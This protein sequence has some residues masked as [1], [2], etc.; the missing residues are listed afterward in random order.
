[1]NRIILIAQSS[2][3]FSCGMLT[4]M[5]I[6]SCS[7]TRT[8]A[9][10][11]KQF[12]DMVNTVAMGW[13]TGNARI[14]ADVF[15]EDAVYEEPP[16]KQ[17]YKGRHQIFEFFGGEK[18]FD[19]PMKMK[20]HNLAFNE[21]DQVGFGEY[22]FAL[23]NQYH[24]IVVMKLEKGKITHWREYQYQSAIDWET[25]TGESKFGNVE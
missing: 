9:I 11:E 25:F 22:T 21:K 23:N 2:K 17:F 13:N 8:D 6:A 1:M 18:G 12:L 19:K 15:A 10:G 14:S 24:G 3:W 4:L 16:R 7:G 5:A 20:W